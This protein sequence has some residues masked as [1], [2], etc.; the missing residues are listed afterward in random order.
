V[1]TEPLHL[2]NEEI[3]AVIDAPLAVATYPNHTQSVERCI[4]LVSDASKAV[5]GY[6]ARDGFIRARNSSR[7]VMPRFDTKRQFA[8]LIEHSK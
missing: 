2:S 5:Y 6:D 4:K 8:P 3:K 7:A 1:I